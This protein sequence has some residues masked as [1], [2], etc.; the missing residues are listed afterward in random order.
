MIH[1]KGKPDVKYIVLHHTAVS[2]KRQALQFN[3]VNTHHR[4]KF[5][6]DA[7]SALGYY[8]GYNFF[9]EPTGSRKQARKVGEETIAN[10]GMN[11]DV[12][13][14]CGAISYCMAGDFRVEKPTNQQV[15]DFREFIKE[16]KKT[17]P[18]VQVVQHKD[19]QKNRTCAELMES[20]LSTIATPVTGTKDEQIAKLRKQ[21]DQLVGMVT[22]L[23]KLLTK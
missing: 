1:F 17:Y 4:V 22:T 12:P 18:K 14:R 5:K 20:E 10:V 23:I 21:N 3:P 13:A 8:V 6:Q 7:P 2:R 9:C 16:V 19:I 15:A 11:C